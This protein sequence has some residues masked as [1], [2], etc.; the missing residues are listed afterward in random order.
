MSAKQTANRI[1]IKD[2]VKGNLYKIGSRNLTLGVYDG[3]CGFIGIREKFN[4]RY[5]DTEYHWDYDG[6]F[7]TVYSISDAGIK[8]PEGIEVIEFFRN[9]KWYRLNEPLFNF[10]DKLLKS[11]SFAS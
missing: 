10:L 6:P 5:L 8:T 2:L 3:D 9:G 7:G 4:Q 1:P 11:P